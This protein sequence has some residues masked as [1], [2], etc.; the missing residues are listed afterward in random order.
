M[1][2]DNNNSTPIVFAGMHGLQQTLGYEAHVFADRTE[3]HLNVDSRH[4]NTQNHLHGGLFSVIL[5]SACGFAAS[6]AISPDASQRV[7]TVSLT[8]NYLAPGKPGAIVARGDVVRA[9][10]RTIFCEGKVF[11]SAGTVLATATGV[12]RSSA[13]T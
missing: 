2:S 4:L 13:K 10:K 11:D 5:D 6:R 9:G 7:V 8:T 3:V 12:F 1:A